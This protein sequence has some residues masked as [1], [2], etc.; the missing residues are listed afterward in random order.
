[1]GQFFQKK[2]LRQV[3]FCTYYFLLVAY[4]PSMRRLQV[5]ACPLLYMPSAFFGVFVKFLAIITLCLL[6][7]GCGIK[8]KEDDADSVS[9]IALVGKWAYGMRGDADNWWQEEIIL[10]SD[11]TFEASTLERRSGV[12]TRYVETGVWMVHGKLF[13]R[14]YK[15]KNGRQLISKNQGYATLE[16]VGSIGEDK[17]EAKDNVRNVLHLFRR[18][19]R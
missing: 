10:N 9:R 11:K 16:I 3:R 6:M 5:A 2:P 7:F 15:T 19:D 17:F 14:Q 13:K 8:S 4:S 12:E 1:M 18:I